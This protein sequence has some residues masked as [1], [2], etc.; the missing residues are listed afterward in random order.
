MNAQTQGL[1]LNVGASDDDRFSVIAPDNL[2]TAATLE[3]HPAPHAFRWRS[4]ITDRTESPMP[5]LSLSTLF[6]A[7]ARRNETANFT[8]TIGA[9]G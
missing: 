3:I 4:R 1:P 2:A 6:A 5:K 9:T 8:L 7:A